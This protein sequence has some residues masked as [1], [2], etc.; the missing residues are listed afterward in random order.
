MHGRVNNLK[1]EEK[2]INIAKGGTRS[3][4]YRSINPL[5]KLPCLQV[6]LT[7]VAHTSVVFHPIL[8][9]PQS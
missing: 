3:Q 2:T 1:V 7:E 9:Q 8:C 4:E 5:G 6:L